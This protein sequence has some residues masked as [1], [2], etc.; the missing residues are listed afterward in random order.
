MNVNLQYALDAVLGLAAIAWICYR[1][2]TWRVVDPAR[3]W[4][5]PLIFAIVG[6]GIIV[7][8]PRTVT[9]NASEIALLAV[10]L[11]VSLGIGAAMG[12]IAHFRR[13]APERAA[14]YYARRA[15]SRR[16]GDAGPVEY[17]SRTSWV[18]L[19]LW[20]AL[21]AVRV[22]LAALTSH[23]MGT[24]STAMTGVIFLVLAANRAARVAV[25]A[26]RLEQHRNSVA[27]TLA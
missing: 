3:M 5:G 2:M 18:G 20:V 23:S 22:G 13:I 21:I 15:V 10:E 6:A 16:G 12:A 26:F 27:E 24:E 17:E 25:L 11:V 7:T 14:A 8:G 19:L 9:L 1:Q 4:R